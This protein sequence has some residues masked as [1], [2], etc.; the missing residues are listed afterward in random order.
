M[1]KIIPPL[2]LVA[3][4]FSSCNNK[5]EV[6]TADPEESRI[7]VEKTLDRHWS[8]VKEG[9]AETILDLLTDDA[10]SCG[11]DSKEFWS[12]TAMAD[13]IRNMFTDSAMKINVKIDKR[14]IRVASDGNSAI[15]LEQ[16]FLEPYSQKIPVRNVYHL[17]KVNNDWKFDFT[18]VSFI[19]DNEDIGKLNEALQ[20]EP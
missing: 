8:A 18:S 4:M 20:Q 13:N 15:A 10:L 6:P 9:D 1:K 3:I 19:P 2:I 12:K 11:S 5:N 17:V 14:I 7:A 16:M